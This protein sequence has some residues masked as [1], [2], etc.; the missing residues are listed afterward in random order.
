MIVET[1]PA[2]HIQKVAPWQVAK[3]AGIKKLPKHEWETRPSLPQSLQIN[4]KPIGLGTRYQIQAH[5]GPIREYASRLDSKRAL[6][7]SGDPDVAAY[8]LR[9]AHVQ[10]R[11]CGP[12]GR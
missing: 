4:S 9:N 5:P 2:R 10:H 1:F 8:R 6:V 12:A 11:R 3:G 7:R